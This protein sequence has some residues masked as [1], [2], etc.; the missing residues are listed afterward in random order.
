MLFRKS[1]IRSL[2]S[3]VGYNGMFL[4]TP[5]QRNVCIASIKGDDYTIRSESQNSWV[6]KEDYFMYDSSYTNQ[7]SKL[8]LFRVIFEFMVP[9]IFLIISTF[10]DLLDLRM[11]TGIYFLLIDL[12]YILEYLIIKRLSKKKSLHLKLRRA[13]NM[14]LNAFEKKNSPPSLEEIQKCSFFRWNRYAMSP[15]ETMIIIFSL[16]VIFFVM[17]TFKMQL[18]ALPLLIC[19]FVLAFKTAFFGVFLLADV[20]SPNTYEMKIARDLIDFWYSSYKKSSAP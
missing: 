10:M 12:G 17:P 13:L 6:I 9:V 19:I 3:G 20:A 2:K 14:A 1:K 18:I 16:L 4:Y 15:G 5:N 7:V 11:R 8:Q